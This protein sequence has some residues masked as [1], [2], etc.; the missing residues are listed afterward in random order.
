VELGDLLSVAM[1]SI[2]KFREPSPEE[3][4]LRN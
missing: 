2:A 4:G 3:E 1:V